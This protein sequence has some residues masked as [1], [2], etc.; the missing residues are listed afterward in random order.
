MAPKIPVAF[1][2]LHKTKPIVFYAM[3]PWYTLKECR[4][5][6]AEDLTIFLFSFL[7]K[8]ELKS[9]LGVIHL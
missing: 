6:L 3:I 9:P 5:L 4:K 8:E 7:E 2:E 1:R